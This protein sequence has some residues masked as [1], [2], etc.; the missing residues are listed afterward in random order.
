[1]RREEEGEKM[2]VT[3]SIHP[4]VPPRVCFSRLMSGDERERKREREREQ[5][6]PPLAQNPQERGDQISDISPTTLSLSIANAMLQTC[7]Q[8][9]GLEKGGHTQP[10][11]KW[12]S[13]KQCVRMNEG[14]AHQAEKAG[15]ICNAFR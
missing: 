10:F 13:A 2:Y 9:R 6:M 15:F 11:S 14:L 5:T 12:A 1:M 8:Q 3:P 7:G 4:F